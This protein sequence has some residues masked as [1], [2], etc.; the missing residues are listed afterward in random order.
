MLTVANIILLLGFMF[1]VNGQDEDVS[2]QKSIIMM[3]ILNIILAF[4]SITSVIHILDIN[5]P[6]VQMY[7]TMVL[8]YIMLSEYTKCDRCG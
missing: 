2:D 1:V 5:N 3:T 6:D 8:L 7:A 4:I